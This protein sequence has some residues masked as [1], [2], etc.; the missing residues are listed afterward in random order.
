M[1]PCITWFGLCRREEQGQQC[2]VPAPLRLHTHL[3]HSCQLFSHRLELSELPRRV[4][5]GSAEDHSGMQ[6]EAGE[7]LPARVEAD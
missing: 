3:Q 1:L 6:S 4:A 2:S 7:G 5:S